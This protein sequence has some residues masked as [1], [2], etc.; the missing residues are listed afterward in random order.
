ELPFRNAVGRYI[1][2]YGKKNC[3]E[4]HPLHYHSTEKMEDACFAFLK[5]FDAY[6]PLKEAESAAKQ[7][8]LELSAYRKAQN[9]QFIAKITKTTYAKNK[10][11]I[12]RIS[13]EIEDLSSGLEHGLLDVDATASEQA[14][15]IKKL[16]SR[17][18]RLRSRL[19]SR[20][21]MLD[22]VWICSTKTVDTLF[23]LLQAPLTICSDFSLMWQW[24][25]L[26][27]L[28]DSTRQFPPCLRQN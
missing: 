5:L 22:P 18:R 28:K 3:D 26:R 11:D 27:K 25:A 23:P 10:N 4:H 9:H 14:V 8:D 16:L 24:L 19:Q 1:R 15:Y 20:L 6:T 12:D 7:S 13:S 2:V 17:A 21:D